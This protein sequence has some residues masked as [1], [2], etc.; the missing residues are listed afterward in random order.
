MAHQNIYPELFL[1]IPKDNKLLIQEIDILNK[2]G[3]KIF[4]LGVI[5]FEESLKQ[6]AQS[7]YCIFPSLKETFGLGLIEGALN[8]CKVLASDL[9]YTYDV[10]EPS[11]VFNPYDPENIAEKVKICVLKRQELNKAI[12]KIENQIEKLISLLTTES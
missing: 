4:N 9:E 6:T 1:T 2:K 7:E 10:L 3:T 8:N 5:T 11:L 12:P